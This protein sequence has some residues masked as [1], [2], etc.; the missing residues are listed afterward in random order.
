M[1]CGMG[2][3]GETRGVSVDD[4]VTGRRAQWLWVLAC[5]LV[6]VCA[7]HVQAVRLEEGHGGFINEWAVHV[8]GGERVARSVAREFG[9]DFVGQVSF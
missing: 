8:P 6:A 2:L 3:W 1:L 7:T 5:L 4:A 9:Y